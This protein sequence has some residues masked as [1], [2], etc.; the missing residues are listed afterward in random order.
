MPLGTFLIIL[1]Q[2]DGFTMECAFIENEGISDPEKKEMFFF[3]LHFICMVIIIILSVHCTSLSA[4]FNQTIMW[5]H[6]VELKI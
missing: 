1:M 5:M 4:D 6:N 2:Y 3:S